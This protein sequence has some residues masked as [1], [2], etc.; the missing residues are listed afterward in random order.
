M[1]HLGEKIGRMHAH[2]IVYE[3]CMKA[4]KDKTEVIDTLLEKEAV[5]ENFTRKELEDIMKPE[6][7]TGLSAE[8]VD[9][10]LDDSKS[11]FK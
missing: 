11:F 10:V 6:L 9:R 8:F 2:E 1:L 5:K 3:A 4:F 7:Y